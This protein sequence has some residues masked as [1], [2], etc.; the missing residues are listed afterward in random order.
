MRCSCE[1]GGEEMSKKLSLRGNF[2]LADN[3]MLTN[4]P[5]FEYE[6]NDLTRGWV[7][8]AAYIWPRTTR[9]SAGTDNGQYQMCASLATDTARILDFEFISDATDNRQIGW[10]QAGYQSRNS[11][12]ADFIANSG[13]SPNPAAFVI[14]PEHVVANGLWLN[15]PT[16]KDGS[17]SPTVSPDRTWNYMVILRPKKLDPKETILHLIKNFAQ[18]VDN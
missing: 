6:A 3:A 16:V 13:N 10:C 11:A 15:F 17:S 9:A 12:I 8:E 14:D 4:H 7:V 18:D 1:K 5:I 2:L